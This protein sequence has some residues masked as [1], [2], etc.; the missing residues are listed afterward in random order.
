MAPSQIAIVPE[1]PRR[2]GIGK[3]DA[4]IQ[5]LLA[6]RE[7]K[8]QRQREE[9]LKRRRE[10]KMHRK[11]EQMKGVSYKTLKVAGNTSRT[12]TRRTTTP[13]GSSS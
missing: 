4:A 1:P 13:I 8:L 12:R 2:Q 3:N 5:Q 6:E 10:E 7:V 9:Q 11:R